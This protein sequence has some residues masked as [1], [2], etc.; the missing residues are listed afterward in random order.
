M[1]VV[2]RRVGRE[3]VLGR[4]RVVV[5]AGKGESSFCGGGVGESRL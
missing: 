1:G 4:M 5:G 3:A 2:R